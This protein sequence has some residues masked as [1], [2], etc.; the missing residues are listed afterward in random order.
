MQVLAPSDG[1][2]GWLP[3]SVGLNLNIACATTKNRFGVEDTGNVVAPQA[4][5]TVAPVTV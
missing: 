2:K 3:W 4:S 5:G 1:R